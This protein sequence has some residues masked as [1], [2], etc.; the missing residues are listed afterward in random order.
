MTDSYG[1]MAAARPDAGC[2]EGGGPCL[3]LAYR[4]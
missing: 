1:K 4:L 3:P 2:V